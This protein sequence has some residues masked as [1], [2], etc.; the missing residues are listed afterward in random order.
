[1]TRE[2]IISIILLNSEAPSCVNSEAI[3]D[4]ILSIIESEKQI[5]P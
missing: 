3:A 4:E 1:M 2:Q 5:K